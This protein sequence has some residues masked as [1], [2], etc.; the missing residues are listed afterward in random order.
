MAMSKQIPALQGCQLLTFTFTLNKGSKVGLRMDDNKAH[1]TPY[2]NE[3]TRS[4][5][6]SGTAMFLPTE[7]KNTE[8][9]H[10]SSKCDRSDTKQL[11]LVISDRSADLREIFI[12]VFG[13]QRW[14]K[15]LCFALPKCGPSW[16][17]TA[18]GCSAKVK[19]SLMQKRKQKN[20]GKNMG[21]SNT[22]KRLITQQ[23]M[24]VDSMS[25]GP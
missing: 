1:S 5:I 19:L 12:H 7:N 4:N 11:I 3:A 18:A 21:L 8:E 22:S 17:E 2:A 13:F 15:Q 6:S 10:T 14:I 9:A 24:K 16:R 20:H 25:E 23:Q